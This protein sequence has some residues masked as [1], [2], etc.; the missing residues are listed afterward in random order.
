MTRENFKTIAETW[1]IFL[2][3]GISEFINIKRELE[4]P[5]LVVS[6]GIGDVV[7]GSI[8]VN[9]DKNGHTLEDMKPFNIVSNL[10]EYE[11]EKLSYF[12]VPHVHTMNKAGHVKKFI[13]LQRHLDEE[14]HHHLRGNI[15]VMGDVVEDIEM[16]KQLSYDN[17]LKI[18]FLNNMTADAHL[19]EKFQEAYDII[20]HKDGNLWIVISIIE[21]IAGRKLQYK[22]KL[23]KDFTDFIEKFEN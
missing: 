2:R 19:Y 4:I 8:E 9:L 17:I 16:V 6:G 18:G 7:R 11:G 21:L 13:D 3:N 20:V 14:S 22:D 10:G 12:N 1:G 15:I 5:L 23:T